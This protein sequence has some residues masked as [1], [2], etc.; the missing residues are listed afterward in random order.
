VPRALKARGMDRHIGRK[1]YSIFSEAGLSPTKIY[2]IPIF[3]TQQ[4]PDALKALVY[5]FVQILEQNKNA[6][7]KESV[8]TERDYEEAMKEVKHFL[9]NHGSFSYISFFLAVGECSG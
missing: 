1:L 5:Q 6:L 3:A 2:P 8:T 9:E 4:D 7:I